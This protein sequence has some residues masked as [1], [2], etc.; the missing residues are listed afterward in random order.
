MGLLSRKKKEDKPCQHKFKDLNS[1]VIGNY[2][3]I[4]SVCSE[5]GL[6][7]HRPVYSIKKMWENDEEEE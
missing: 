7:V 1:V 5:C 3:R 6:A 4:V 2:I